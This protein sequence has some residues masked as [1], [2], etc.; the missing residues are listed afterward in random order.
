MKSALRSL[1]ALPVAQLGRHPDVVLAVGVAAMV[2]V[3][4][5]PLPAFLLDG[6]LAT[7]LAAAALVLVAVLLADRALALSTFP[8][9]LLITTLFRL[10]LN[11]S[12]TRMILSKGSAGEVVR[13]FGEFVVQG[14]V[15]VGMVV[16][17]VITLVQFLVIGKG[18]ERVAEVGARFTLDAMPGKQM[19]IEASIRAG[20]LTEEEGQSRRED[21]DRESQFYA[22]MDGA[23]KFVKGDAIAGLVITGLNLIAGLAIG[24]GRNGLSAG[25]AAQVY[26]ILTVGD[27]LVSQ[28]PA[29]LITLSAGILTTRVAAKD[30]HTS[31]GS[32]LKSELFS[33]PKALAIGAAFALVLGLIPG[34]P[35]VPFA[36][37]A[38]GLGVLAWS[39]R[40][41]VAT[42]SGEASKDDFQKRL[43]EKVK[44]AKAQRAQVDA[45]APTVPGVGIDIEATLAEAL[46]L[47][48]SRESELVGQLIPEIRDALFMDMGVR[49]PGARVRSSIP[50]MRPGEVVFRIKDVP[51]AKELLPLGMVMAV[52]SPERLRR[53]GLEA[54]PT[55]NPINGAEASWV[56]EDQ[57]DALRDAGVTVWG[58]EAVIA[59]HLARILRKHAKSF[60]GLQETADLLERLEKA[61]PTLVREVVPKLVTVNQLADILRRLVD[62]G[63]SIRDLKSV[64]EALA[65]HACHE[66]DGV[67]LTELVRASLSL[68]IAHQFAGMGGRLPVVLLDPII[69]DTIRSAIVHAPSGSYLAL[70]PELRRAILGSTARVVAPVV[71]AGVRPVILTNADVRR[72]VR[73]LID[74][75]MSQVAVLSLQELPSELTIQPL[76]RVSIDDEGLVMAA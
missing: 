6:L 21:L 70:E 64:L 63:I 58:L 75:D 46:G 60:V 61:Y 26:S 42:A 8:T 51:V 39:R 11:V 15:I 50:G 23:M 74:E 38:A 29:L 59:L 3:L 53:F 22:A 30:A 5:L 41:G 25:E 47:T 72:Y 65:D 27:G 13:A 62:E 66:N 12:T 2:A 37:L 43:D 76:G 24:V 68:Q 10:G 17:L 54:A 4:I 69:E 44:Q 45:M 49:F 52:D 18:A 34:L 14:D 31:L 71:S 57:A 73:K 48:A 40:G 56:A 36:V 19:S 1:E 55:A 16:F 33:R 7:N 9:L 28:I 32:S 67:A 20:A 35:L